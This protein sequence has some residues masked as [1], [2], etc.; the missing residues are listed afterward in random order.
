MKQQKI[1]KTFNKIFSIYS[2]EDLNEIFNSFIDALSFTVEELDGYTGYHQIRVAKL[3]TK[4]A[5]E[6][7]LSIDQIDNVQLSARVHDVGKVRIPAPILTRVNPLLPL[8]FDLIKQH[9]L[10]GAN[11]LKKIKHFLVIP[12]VVEQHHEKIDGSGYPYG[13]KGDDIL[14]ES[15]IVC[16]SD[17]VDAMTNIRPYRPALGLDTA[18]NEIE[19]GMG[20]LYNTKVCEACKSVFKKG[21]TIQEGV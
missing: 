12:K 1:Y 8:E 13:I 15:Q 3:A 20:I 7:D 19:K 21:F 4:I 11:I 17:I 5:E 10:V 9:T 18:L 14:L 6:L 16:V 2:D